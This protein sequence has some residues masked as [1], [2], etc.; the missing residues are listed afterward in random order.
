MTAY[1]KRPNINYKTYD[2]IYYIALDQNDAY[3][4]LIELD[5]L[6]KNSNFVKDITDYTMENSYKK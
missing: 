4:D 1:T 5:T 3:Q 6:F 2:K